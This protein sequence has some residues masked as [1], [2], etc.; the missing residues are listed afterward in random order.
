VKWLEVSLETSAENAEAVADVLARFASGGTS[1]TGEL[2]TPEAPLTVRAYLAQDAA[3]E[4]AQ[5]RVR[6]AIWHLS[7]ISSLP[8]PTFHW[9]E[10]EDWA[11]SW[12]SH[13]RP[14]EAGRSLMIVPAW[15]KAEDPTRRPLF[16]EPGMA[17]GTGAH[18]STRL[19][20]EALEGLI[21]PGDTVV[22]IGCGSGILSIAARFFGAARVLAC[23]L[24]DQ[25]IR[26]TLLS[27]EL[28]DIREGLEVFHG[29]LP[30]V[31]ARL[32]DSPSADVLVANIL[33]PTL[34]EMLQG[35]LPQV[36]RPEGRII[37]A[38]ILV[39]QRDTVAHAA[40]SAGLS[41]DGE[42]VEGDWVALIFRRI[43]SPRP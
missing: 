33:A 29:S 11:E 5:E 6:E 15:M 8:E 24:D 12:K 27:A 23:D 31:A 1:I 7:Q 14:I 34:I 43:G 25:A 26:A 19:C 21:R 13:F 16:L 38:G 40:T 35:G 2:R 42:T 4:T 20:L 39:D 32:A 28:N 37:L 18:P 3:S 10:G 41:I 9:I 22:D 36:V 17:F 30:E